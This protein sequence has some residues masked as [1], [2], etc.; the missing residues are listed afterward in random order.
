VLHRN[1]RQNFFSSSTSVCLARV[2]EKTQCNVSPHFAGERVRLA[3]IIPNLADDNVQQPEA[4]FP[5][6]G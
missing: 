5:V 3:I 1:H 2:G 6:I 4:Q